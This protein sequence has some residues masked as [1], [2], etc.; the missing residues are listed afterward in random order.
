MKA[1]IF[2]V[3]LV[4][5][6]NAY[7][8][9]P[10]PAGHWRGS[11]QIPGNTFTLDVDVAKNVA[12]EFIGT[13][14][15]ADAKNIPLAKI[16]LDGQQIRFYARADQAFSGVLSEDEQSISGSIAIAGYDLPLDLT[17]TGDAVIA[18][19]PTSNPITRQLEGTWSGA[20]A[21]PTRNMRLVL[22]LTNR[23]DGRSEG[24]FVSLDEGGMRLPVLITQDASAVT[25]HLSGI[26][27]TY[28]SVLNAAGTELTGTF[29][30]GGAG[31]PLTL[32]R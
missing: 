21:T 5:A 31:L 4:T 1:L 9:S 17:R 18:P 29:T 8:Q 16:T 32:T 28:S 25:I 13:A 23:P 11:L 2:T 20:L 27:G 14:S 30:Q 12:G 15:S 22:N 3:T 19:A 7:A 24:Y 10:N 26:D 6:A